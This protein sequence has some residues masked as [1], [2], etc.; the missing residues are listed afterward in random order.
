MKNQETEVILVFHKDDPDGIISA[1]LFLRKFGLNVKMVPCAY[2]DQERVFRQLCVKAKGRVIYIGDICAK[3]YPMDGGE[4]VLELLAASA[5]KIVWFDNHPATR[6][7]MPLFKKYGHEII[8]G[9]EQQICAAKLIQE[10]QL[11]KDWY[12]DFLAHVAQK[13][14]YPPAVSTTASTLIEVGIGLQKVISYYNSRNDTRGRGL[15]ELIETIAQDDIWCLNG[16]FCLSFKQIIAAVDELIKKAQAESL[17]KRVFINVKGK[18]FLIT[19]ADEILYDK[20]ILVDL[21][22]KLAGEVDG[23]AVYF[24]PPVGHLLFFKGRQS[25][26]NAQE[27]C[28]FMGGGGRE[29]NGGFSPLV[30][31]GQEKFEMFVDFLAKKLNQYI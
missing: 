31:Y 16:K 24:L 28:E 7:F 25:D 22:D 15:I 9:D 12:A 23:V 8:M 5:K 1:A 21:R 27:F 30:K 14:D 11:P 26:F 6:Y 3:D 19:C 20:K 4:T 17:K 29:G 2:Q 18:R 10:R 13:S